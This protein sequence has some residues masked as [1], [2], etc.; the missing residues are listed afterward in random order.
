MYMCL[1][2][3]AAVED[4][5]ISLPDE[6]ISALHADVLLPDPHHAARGAISPPAFSLTCQVPPLIMM[7]TQAVR[8]K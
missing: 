7:C 8:M 4:E 5:E 6:L 3:A 1:P 2:R